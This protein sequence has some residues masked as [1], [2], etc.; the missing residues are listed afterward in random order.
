MKKIWGIAFGVV[1]GLL[2][3]GLLFLATGKPRGEPVK[4]IPPP[5]PAPLIVHVAGAVEDP[6]VVILAHGSRVQDAVDQAGGLADTADSSL[7]NLAKPLEDGMQVWVPYK[8]DTQ[9]LDMVPDTGN[10]DHLLNQPGNLV[11]INTATQAELETLS[12]IG[13]VIA[14]AIIQYRLD[15]G[16]FKQIG[17]IQA[18][19]GIGPATFEKIKASITLGGAAGD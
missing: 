8:Q 5:T 13:P 10:Q 19:K 16:P 11:N 17:D 3:S 9:V 7:I 12:G 4:L 15:H 1:C 18:V 14:S 6:G 2:G